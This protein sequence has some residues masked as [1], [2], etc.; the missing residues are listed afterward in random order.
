MAHNQMLL[1]TY[2]L[3]YLRCAT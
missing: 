2:L 3:T 1:L